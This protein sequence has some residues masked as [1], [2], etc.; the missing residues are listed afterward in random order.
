[1]VKLLLS[2]S[3]FQTIEAPDGYTALDGLRRHAGDISA[4][5]TDIEMVGMNGVDLATFVRAEFPTIPV[6]FV[7][8]AATSAEDIGGNLLDS[9][10]VRKP[11]TPTELLEAVRKMLGC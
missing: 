6:L 10:F 8:A 7:S 4:L 1:M 3:G 5:V 11:F 9:G 2:R